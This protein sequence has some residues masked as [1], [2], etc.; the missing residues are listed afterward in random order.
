MKLKPTTFQFLK[1]IKKNNNREW[2]NKNK[3]SFN[4][5]SNDFKGFVEI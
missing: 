4:E 2:F 3:N 5:A 1:D